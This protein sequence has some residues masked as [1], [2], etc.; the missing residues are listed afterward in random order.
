MF[1]KYLLHSIIREERHFMNKIYTYKSIY[2]LHIKNFIEMKRTFG[3]KYTRQEG[4]LFLIDELAYQRKESQE[5]ITKE[6]V[7]AWKKIT[8]NQTENYTYSRVSVLALFSSYL[9]DLGIKTYIP[10]LPP[11][12]KEKYA[13]PYIYSIKEVNA[14]FSASDGLRLQIMSYNSCL[15]SIPILLRFLYATGLRIGEAL[16]LKIDKVNLEK[17]YILIKDSKNSKERIIPISESLAVTLKDYIY[18]RNK[19][20]LRTKSENLFIKLNGDPL[21][22]TGALA[23]QFRKCL[24]KAGIQFTGNKQGPRIHDLRHTFACHSLANMARSGIDLYTS[25]P[26][27][28]AYL[29]HQSLEATNRYVRLTSNIFPELIEDID[30]LCINVFP[31]TEEYE[32]N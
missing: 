24:L 22:H 26:I 4:M 29:G 25:L 18:Y 3:Y 19:L 31:K 7:E 6:F 21:R 2:A 27:L 16:I 1:R 14:L 23:A 15:F 11:S 13:L 8:R 17:N 32:S 5:G 30:A 28:S 10:K 12:R 9:S 20:P